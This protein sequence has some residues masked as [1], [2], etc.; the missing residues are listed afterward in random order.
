[1]VAPCAYI[2]KLIW[3]WKEDVCIYMDDAYELTTNASF[4]FEATQF[5]RITKHV[6]RALNILMWNRKC[7]KQS[8][9]CRQYTNAY[10]VISNRST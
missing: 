6:W 9:D 3:K 10:Q 7:N 5:V 8:H 1:M 2:T 4:Y